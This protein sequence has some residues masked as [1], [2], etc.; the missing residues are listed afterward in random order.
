MGSVQGRGFETIKTRRPWWKQPGTLAAL[1]LFVF[2]GAVAWFLLKGPE[3]KL[4]VR[5][6]AYDGISPYC[7][8]ALG[9]RGI[10]NDATRDAFEQILATGP[11][12]KAAPEDV[13]RACAYALGMTRQQ[14]VVLYLIDA[15]KKDPSL[16][17]K[18]AATRALGKTGEPIALEPVMAALGAG[19]DGLREAAAY[20]CKD[21]NNKS[22]IDP[23]IERVEDGNPAVRRAVHEA[24]V[25]LSGTMFDGIDEKKSWQKWRETH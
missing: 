15:L 4:L 9:W 8:Y 6:Q 12:D 20:A 11:T 25:S 7:A 19:D 17:V 10:K 3:E 18:C 2:L 22:A 13:R 24:L 1:A 5:V 21:L 16:P 23:L 14:H